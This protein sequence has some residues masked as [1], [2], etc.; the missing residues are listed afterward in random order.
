MSAI[1]PL[2]WRSTKYT[3]THVSTLKLRSQS[4]MTSRMIINKRT[5]FLINRTCVNSIRVLLALWCFG[6]LLTHS[7]ARK[8]RIGRRWA[9]PFDFNRNAW[10]LGVR[11][12]R[13]C[14]EAERLHARMPLPDA[15]TTTT[16]RATIT[17]WSYC[18]DTGA[19]RGSYGRLHLSLESLRNI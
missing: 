15:K 7:E 14:P 17:Q 19:V 4:Q 10:Q 8:R 18:D 9:E 6:V 12:G 5:V 2:L 1:A 11:T 13:R 16:L 3:R